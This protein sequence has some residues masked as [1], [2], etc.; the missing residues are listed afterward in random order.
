MDLYTDTSEATA[1]LFTR[2]YSTSFSSATRLLP[3]AYR[4]HIYNIYGL[5]R[6]AD[7]IVDTYRGPDALEIL[8]ALET[9]VYEAIAR[10]YSVNP[11]VHAFQGTARLYEI[12]RELIA[13]FFTSMRMDLNTVHTLSK[14]QYETYIYGSAEVVGLMCLAVF[15]QGDKAAY[16]Q[17]RDGACR[18]GAAYQK[19]NFL[20]DF[21]DDAGRLQR[22]YF[23]G[24]KFRTFSDTAKNAIAADIQ[25]DFSAAE[26]YVRALPKAVQ[27]AVWASYMYYFELLT[28]LK[29]TPAAV[30]KKQRLRVSALKKAR[31][32]VRAKTAALPV[33]TAR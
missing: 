7:E 11:I 8:A 30:I 17:L 26:P 27:P 1:E 6:V 12:D 22:C 15:T 4:K 16:T 2:S 3:L 14:K 32:L 19:V 31:L 13:P 21:A 28:I 10:G 33:R 24:V 5:V 18:L 23:P 29:R 25:A 20:R 9:E